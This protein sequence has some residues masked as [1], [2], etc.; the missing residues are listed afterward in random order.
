MDYTVLHRLC[1]PWDCKE[2][3]TT[4]RLS[5]HSVHTHTHTHTHTAIFFLFT[6]VLIV[7]LSVTQAQNRVFA[8]LNLKFYLHNC[9]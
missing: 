5:L 4:E 8:S 2:S 9:F 1:S 7:T 3:D 6:H